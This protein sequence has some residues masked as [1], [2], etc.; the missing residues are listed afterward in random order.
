MTET[1]IRAKIANLRGSEAVVTLKNGRQIHG[2]KV[3]LSGGRMKFDFD[4]CD[5]AE[6]A[7]ISN[8]TVEQR[9]PEL[10]RGR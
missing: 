2:C 3:T 5:F 9:P 10:D 1:E 8:F 6:I 4:E 7:T